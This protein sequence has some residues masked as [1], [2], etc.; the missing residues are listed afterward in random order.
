MARYTYP[1]VFEQEPEGGFSIYFPDIDGCY[2]QAEDIDEGI[3]N[4]NDALCFM[5]YEMEKSVMPI[6]NA[7]PIN[8][9]I[10]RSDS[11]VKLISCDTSLYKKYFEN[12]RQRYC[13]SYEDVYVRNRNYTHAVN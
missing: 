12:K 4:A 8:D 3:R 10:P 13:V 7:T 2:T 9:L 11:M 1:A 6:P 5:L